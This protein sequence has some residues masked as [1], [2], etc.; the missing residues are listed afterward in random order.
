LELI[1][2]RKETFKLL[3]YTHKTSKSI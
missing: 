1:K 3:K 2:N